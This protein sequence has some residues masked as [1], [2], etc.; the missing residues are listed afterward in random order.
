M[1]DIEAF[2]SPAQLAQAIVQIADAATRAIGQA[3]YLPVS[4]KQG[5]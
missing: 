3:G 5:A 2:F 4:L 1:T